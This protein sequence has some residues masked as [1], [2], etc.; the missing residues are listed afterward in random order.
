[1]VQTN[2]LILDKIILKFGAIKFLKVRYR[3]LKA[4]TTVKSSL[5]GFG[6]FNP[7]THRMP[8]RWLYQNQSY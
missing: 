1:M 5:S 2:K 7:P 8:N 6:K 3:V 4:V